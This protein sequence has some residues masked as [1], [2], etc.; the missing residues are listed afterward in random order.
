MITRWDIDRAISE[1]EPH[2]RD[3]LHLRYHRQLT[4]GAISRIVSRSRT[5]VWHILDRLPEQLADILNRLPGHA[6]A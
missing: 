5:Y 2:E 4:H 1:L 3:I 6:G